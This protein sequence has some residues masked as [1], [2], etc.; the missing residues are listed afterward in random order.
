MDAKIRTL[1]TRSAD[2]HPN[3]LQGSSRVGMAAICSLKAT[4]NIRV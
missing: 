1:K 2:A 4:M 3:K